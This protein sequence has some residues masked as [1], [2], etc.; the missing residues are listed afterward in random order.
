MRYD[1][2]VV[3]FFFSFDDTIYVNRAGDGKLAKDFGSV[4][5][6][7][8]GLWLKGETGLRKQTQGYLGNRRL[9][10]LKARNQIERKPEKGWV[11]PVLFFARSP[12][13]TFF[14]KTPFCK[15]GLIL[16]IF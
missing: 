7:F 3:D 5:R 9:L 11:K 6:R 1:Q 10:R 2:K 8:W 12:G 15:C 4:M 14:L 16:Q 13:P